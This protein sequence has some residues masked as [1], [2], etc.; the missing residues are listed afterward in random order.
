M[1]LTEFWTLCSS[2]GI[3]LDLKQL[4]QFTRYAEELLYWNEKVNMISRKDIDNIVERHLLHSLSILK[5][6]DIPPKSRCL[7]IGT[8]G[9]LPG[10]PIAITNPDIKMLLIDSIAKKIK[11]TGMLASHTGHRSIK[12]M[13]IRAEELANLKDHKKKYDFIFARAVTRTVK[14]I[15]WAGGLM[16]HSGKIVLLKGGDL[17]GELTEA[18]EYYPNYDIVEKNIQIIGMDWFEKEEKK[19]IIC[20]KRK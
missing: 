8:G 17:N 2:N 1:E 13:K 10:I 14:I 9:G 18:R 3:V 6:V 5:Y 11:V 19:I 15:S 12:A 7:D 20:N 16:K 4:K